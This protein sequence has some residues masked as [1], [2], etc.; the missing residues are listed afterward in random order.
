MVFLVKVLEKAG[1]WTEWNLFG[2]I[3]WIP[4]GCSGW[5]ADAQSFLCLAKEVNTAGM[6]K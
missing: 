3:T 6:S 5:K 4:G 2:C 1:T